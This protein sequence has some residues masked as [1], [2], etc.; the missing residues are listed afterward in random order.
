MCAMRILQGT[1]MS[2]TGQ[3]HSVR[4]SHSHPPVTMY[5]PSVVPGPDRI[6]KLRSELGTVQQN[7]RVFGEILTEL[8][9]GG[10][11]ADDITLLEV[12]HA[13][14]CIIA[15]LPVLHCMGW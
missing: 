1:A 9:S 14:C 3:H 15:D 12:L 11:T 6:G 5:Q 10:G 8:S 4:K 7:C 2:P 13:L